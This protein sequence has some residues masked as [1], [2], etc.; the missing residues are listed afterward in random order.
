MASLAF[1][2]YKI[3]FRP[4]L[5]HGPHW[6]S[7]Q[8]SPKPPSRLGR[9]ILRPHSPPPST[10]GVEARAWLARPLFRCLCPHQ[11][12]SNLPPLCRCQLW[13]NAKSVLL[14]EQPKLFYKNQ[15]NYQTV[16]FVQIHTT[17]VSLISSFQFLFWSSVSFVH[18]VLLL[19][20]LRRRL[21][22]F[23]CQQ[24]PFSLPFHS[25]PND[26]IFNSAYNE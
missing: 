9:G 10:F 19:C 2:Y 3:Q 20:H 4:R 25:F 22:I 14:F 1:R 21:S 7:L 13:I 24:N 5:H 26:K 18:Q 8:R 16:L 12:S 15:T 11:T 17:N 6:R 23:S